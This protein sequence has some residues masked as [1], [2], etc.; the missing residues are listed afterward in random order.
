MPE[1]VRPAVGASANES[2]TRSSTART[3]RRTVLVG[4][5]W[6]TPIVVVAASAPAFA[7]S[8]NDL[9]FT[10]LPTYGTPAKTYT[11][12]VNLASTAEPVTTLQIRFT[13]DTTYSNATYDTNVNNQPTPPSGWTRTTLTSTVITYTYN[14]SAVPTPMTLA[15]TFQNVRLNTND[16]RVIIDVLYTTGGVTTVVDTTIVTFAGGT[17]TVS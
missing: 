12:S 6:A 14:T 17:V 3:T 16:S 4:A 10:T 8:V 1:L 11:F 13:L 2:C 9:T 5:A 15:A 7:A